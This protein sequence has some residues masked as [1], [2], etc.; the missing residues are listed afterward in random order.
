[1]AT[2]CQPSIRQQESLEK[3]AAEYAGKALIG[4]VDVDADGA[5]ADRFE[6]RTLPGI[7][8]FARGELVESLPGFQPEDFL[9]A[10]IEQLLQPPA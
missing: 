3:L 7:L 2:W 9:R 4:T 6:V 1:M 8:L 5:I 10:C